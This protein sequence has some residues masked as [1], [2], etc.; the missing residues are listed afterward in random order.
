MEYFARML[1]WPAGF[2]DAIEQLQGDKLF[3]RDDHVRVV[4]AVRPTTEEIPRLVDG[5]GAARQD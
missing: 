4:S 3:S 5:L 1:A 2:H